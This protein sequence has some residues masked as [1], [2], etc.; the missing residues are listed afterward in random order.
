MSAPRYRKKFVPVN[1]FSKMSVQPSSQERVSHRRDDRTEIFETK[2]ADKTVIQRNKLKTQ[3]CKMFTETGYCKFGNGCHFAHDESEIRKPICLFGD[4]CKDKKN[5][6]YDHSTEK[7]PELPK[8]P[9]SA[10]FSRREQPQPA[11]KMWEVEVSPITKDEEMFVELEP[12]DTFK[13]HDKNNKLEKMK[14]MMEEAEKDADFKLEMMT[15][16]K[17]FMRET[18]KDDNTVYIENPGKKNLKFIALEVDDDEYDKII[19]YIYRDQ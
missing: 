13:I 6:G 3:M 1:E 10:P 5:C 14:K 17:T 19:E 11:Q 16:M 2:I 15:M 4:K 18:F 7:I 12:A 9:L 8:E